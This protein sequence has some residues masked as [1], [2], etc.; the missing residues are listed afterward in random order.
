MFLF[1]ND[2]SILLSNK[3]YGI[4]ILPIK[5]INLCFNLII[6]NNYYKADS[7]YDTQLEWWK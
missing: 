4:W 1:E 6:K 2:Q 5:K 3:T 7:K